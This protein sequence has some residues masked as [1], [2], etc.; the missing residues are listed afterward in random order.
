M[1]IAVRAVIDQRSSWFGFV[2][3][4][5]TRHITHQPVPVAAGVA[6]V[7]FPVSAGGGGV[8]VVLF[9]V[10]L[11]QAQLRCEPRPDRREEL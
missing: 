6:V 8:A 9:P 1:L 5:Q 3:D 10:G 4:W 7:L 11:P 2:R